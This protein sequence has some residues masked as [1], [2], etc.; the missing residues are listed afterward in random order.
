MWARLRTLIGNEP[1]IAARIAVLPLT[2]IGYGLYAAAFGQPNIAPPA[3]I[4]ALLRQAAAKVEGHRF[5]PRFLIGEW[6]DVADA[7][8]LTRREEYRDVPRLGRKTRI[9]GKQRELLW[10]IFA[11]LRTAIARR[12]RAEA[13]A[14]PSAG[15]AGREGGG[16]EAVVS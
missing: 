15:K 10:T 12:L 11:R 8:Q 4:D 1:D 3:L 16:R 2:G 6:R 13:G 9:G 7:W 5:S 14:S